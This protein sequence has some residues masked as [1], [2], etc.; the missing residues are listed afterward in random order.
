MTEDDSRI[1]GMSMAFLGTV[2]PFDR[3]RPSTL[4]RYFPDAPRCVLRAQDADGSG[5]YVKCYGN[6]VD[7]EQAKRGH[8]LWSER[9]EPRD[10]DAL[11]QALTVIVPEIDAH[12][13]QDCLDGGHLDAMARAEVRAEITDLVDRL[14]SAGLTYV[15]FHRRNVLVSHSEGTHRVH[16]IDL[17]AIRSL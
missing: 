12:D 3:I 6:P 11:D 13:L 9:V 8:Q 2:P 10:F 14:N 1:P 15:D 16:L 7:Y 17:D 5:Y 4:S